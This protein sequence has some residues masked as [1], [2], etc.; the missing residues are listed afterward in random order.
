MVISVKGT[1][2]VLQSAT[3]QES[4]MGTILF[5]RQPWPIGNGRTFEIQKGRIYDKCG[6]K[7]RNW[8]FRQINFCPLVRQ[9]SRVYVCTPPI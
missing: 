8:E 5:K 2:F 7:E 6:R 3:N 1:N 9:Q 4:K